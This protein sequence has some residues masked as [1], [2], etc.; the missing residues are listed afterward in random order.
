MR[1]TV[2]IVDD[3][4]P[5]RRLL[6]SLASKAGW[7][8][9]AAESAYHALKEFRV[10]RFGWAFC[11]VDLG[12]GMDGID[13]AVALRR[14]DPG[15]RIRMMIGSPQHAGR[16]QEAGFPEFRAKPFERAP[17]F[18]MLRGWPAG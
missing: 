6:A 4:P 7:E 15:L 11:D 2:L 17:V 18:R 5:V 16:A 14:C 3:S 13:L 10:G 9:V 12:P 8:V 1:K